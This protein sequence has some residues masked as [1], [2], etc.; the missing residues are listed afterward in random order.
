MIVVDTSALMA[1]V[2]GEPEADACAEALEREVDI[3]ISGGT[4]A[5]ALIVSARR[6]VGAEMGSLIDGLGFEIGPVTPTSARNAADAYEKWG[7]GLHPAGLNF[8]DCF[9]Y[10][11]AKER[12]CALLYTGSDFSKTDISSALAPA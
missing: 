4:V 1:I 10:A 7:K 9:A 11:R 12:G 6:N 5:E 8:G 2:L 3:L